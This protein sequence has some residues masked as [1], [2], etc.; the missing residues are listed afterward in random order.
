MDVKND[1]FEDQMERLTQLGL[2]VAR[3]D[4]SLKERMEAYENGISVAKTCLSMLSEAERK[5]DQL[6]K[7]LETMMEDQQL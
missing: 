1:S 6:S 3:K 5:A 7:E 2:Q 4:I